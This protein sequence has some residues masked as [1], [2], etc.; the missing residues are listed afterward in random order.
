M[1]KVKAIMKLHRILVL[2]GTGFV[3]RH[4]VPRLAEQGYSIRIPTRHAHRH[5]DFRVLP[6]VNL[7][8]ADIH[9]SGVLESLCNDCDAVI[10]LVGILNER[11][12]DGSGFHAVHATLT[13]NAL[14]A[15][16][17]AGVRRFVQMSALKADME[18][19]PSHYLRS[20]QAAEQAVFAN[21]AFP[22]TVFR[23]SVIFGPD[24]S[25]MNRFAD[26]LK[27]APFMPLASAQ[28]RFAPV[29]VGDVVE[30]F[31]NCLEDPETFGKGFELCG[32]RIYSLQELVRY[33]GKLIGKRRPVIALPEWAGAL[34]ARLFEYVPGKP[35]SRDNLASLSVDSICSGDSLPCP[36]LLES[37]APEYLGEQGRQAKMQRLRTGLRD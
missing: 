17:A 35:L 4:L 28:S 26:L 31:V 13:S 10:N 32:P 36:T 21:T 2:G 33:T 37:V 24:D 11:G 16:E 7:I 9:Q 3:G 15:A 29:F 6:E 20:K 25:F 34:Q 22:V 14:S 27:I 18:N 8:E 12:S 5:R 19:P 1:N 23:P 30:H